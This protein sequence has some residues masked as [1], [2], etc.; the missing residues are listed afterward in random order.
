MPSP[1]DDKRQRVAVITGSS[2]GIGLETAL[3]LARNGFVVYATMRDLAK[4]SNLRTI[5][6][7]EHLDIRTMQLDVTEDS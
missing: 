7:K 4:A 3:M 2:S 1:S 6:E 5:A